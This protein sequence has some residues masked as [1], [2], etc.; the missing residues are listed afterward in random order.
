MYYYVD[1][2][3]ISKLDVK[4]E[5]ASVINNFIDEYYDDYTGLYLRSKAF[6]KN[7]NNLK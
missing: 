5:Y 2:E 1:I 6:L 4:M 7:L 3:K